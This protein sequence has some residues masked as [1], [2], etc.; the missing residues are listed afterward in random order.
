MKDE[1]ARLVTL[2]PDFA[3]V[4]AL[5]MTGSSRT[6][7]GVEADSG[8]DRPDRVRQ[9][10]YEVTVEAVGAAVLAAAEE[11]APIVKDPSPI[12]AP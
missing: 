3:L 9:T 4:M 12:L 8:A 5:A 10:T 6:T 1:E 11:V 7:A 2:D